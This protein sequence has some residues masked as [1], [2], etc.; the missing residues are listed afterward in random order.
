[1]ADQWRSLERQL[2]ADPNDW[3]V[4]EE[5]YHALQRSG[6]EPTENPAIQISLESA[7]LQLDSNLDARRFMREVQ[8]LGYTG[9]VEA[10]PDYQIQLNMQ[11]RGCRLNLV[12]TLKKHDLKL[13]P[14][15]VG[16]YRV[17][18]M[19]SL[20]DTLYILLTPILHTLQGEKKQKEYSH[21]VIS[22]GN[23]GIQIERE[24]TLPQQTSIRALHADNTVAY[25]GRRTNEGEFA[26]YR[27]TD[28]ECI[29]KD[30]NTIFAVLPNSML[31]QHRP[32]GL[33]ATYIEGQQL[34]YRHEVFAP[35]HHIGFFCAPDFDTVLEATGLRGSTSRV[36]KNSRW[37][38]SQ[39]L[40]PCNR[41]TTPYDF[42]QHLTKKVVEVS[43]P[44]ADKILELA[45]E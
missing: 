28:D 25:V 6:L 40:D 26:L 21:A 15:Q 39:G 42:F 45:S 11:G 3:K 5:F 34:Y 14:A 41:V 32:I 30:M 43:L 8:P 13:K 38:V 37:S 19:A 31:T 33:G 4:A 44:V 29:A 12:E 18:S 7:R 9:L 20:Q 16:T 24:F 1:M 36:H 27:L 35:A 2:Q 22:I 17:E 23:E 10:V